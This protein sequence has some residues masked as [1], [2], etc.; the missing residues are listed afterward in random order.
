M[1]ASAAAARRRP[2]RAAAAAAAAACWASTRAIWLRS[3]GPARL[4]GGER[5]LLRGAGARSAASREDEQLVHPGQRVGAQLVAAA[6]WRTSRSS[7]ASR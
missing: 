4:A 1:L 2:R 3:A 7:V 6:I 5:R